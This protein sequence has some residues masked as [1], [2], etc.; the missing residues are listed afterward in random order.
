MG[1]CGVVIFD[2]SGMREV[3]GVR[4]WLVCVFRRVDVVCFVV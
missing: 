4:F 1:V 2:L 3:G